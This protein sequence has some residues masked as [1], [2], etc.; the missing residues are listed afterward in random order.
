MDRQAAMKLLEDTFGDSF[1][2][3][4]FSKFVKELFNKFD[5]SPKSWNVWKEYADYIDAYQLLGSHKQG[6]QVIDVLAVKLKKSTSIERARTMQRNFV[7]KYLGNAGKDAALVAFY[8]EGESDWRFSFVKME[9]RL[10]EGDRGKIKVEKELTPAKRYSFLVGK[11]EPNHTCKRQFLSL[12]MEEEKVP[13]IDDIESA[14]SVEKVTKEFFNEYKD[15]YLEL[16]ES[17]VKVLEKDSRARK[18]F[19]EKGITSVDFSKKLLGQIVFIYFL[20]KKGW[21][22]VSRKEKDGFLSWGSGPKNFLRKL[23][24]KEIVPYDNFFNDILEP[25]FYEALA[26]QRDDDYYSRFNCKIPFLNGG[27]FEPIG[28]Y[29]W[30]TTDI[31]LDNSIFKR[32]LDTFDRYNFTIKEDE[33]LEKEVAIDPEMLGKVFENL[34]EIKDRKSKGSYYT[35]REIVHYMCQ[36][37][38]IN[39]LETNVSIP[40]EDIEKFVQFGEFT[41]AEDERILIRVKEINEEM[42]RSPGKVN[43]F[44]KE[45]RKCID[46]LSLPNTIFA[47]K[48]KIDALLKEVKIV[49]PA[50]GSGAFP[51][52]MMT[53]IVKARSVLTPFFP[54]TERK[55]RTDYNLKR[56]TIENC[57]YGVDI[58][59]SA[60]DITKLRFWLSLIVDELDM[61]NIKPLPN[62]DHKIM[63]GNSLLDEFEG[64]KL[65]DDALLGEV[66]TNGHEKERI[67]KEMKALYLELG[68]IHKGKKKAP[69]S[70]VD[71][72]KKELKKLERRKKALLTEPKDDSGQATLQEAFANKV[73]QSKVKLNELKKL[74]KQFFNEQDRKLKKQYKDQI[75][76]IEWEL[77]EETLKEQGN[78]DAMKKLAQYKKSRSKPFFLWKLYFAEVFQRENPG[79]DIVIAN[80]PYVENKKIDKYEKERYKANYESAY[81]LFDL[82]VL[83]I[84]KTMRILKRE[85]YMVFI[86]TNK[87]LASDYGIKIRRLILDKTSIEKLIDVSHIRVFK[88]AAAFP[89]IIS[90]VNETPKDNSVKIYPDIDNTERFEKGLDELEETIY[91]KDYLLTTDIIFNISS[92]IEIAIKMA[93]DD[94]VVKLSDLEPTFIYRPLGFTDWGTMIKHLEQK[95]SSNSLKFI[96]TPNVEKYHTNWEKPVIVN[97]TKVKKAFMPFQ[98]EY[99]EGWKRL[100]KENLMIKEIALNLT[101]SY[102][103]GNYCHLTGVYGLIT[104]KINQKYLLGL[105]NSR[106]LNFYYKSYY[107]LI[108]L[109]GGY[110]K[111]N[112]SY[113]K[114]LP[115]KII[116]DKGQQPIIKLV[117]QILSITK[118]EDYPNNPDKQTKV[119]KLEKEI[120]Q[121]VY[122]LYGLTEEEIRIVEGR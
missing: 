78:E 19:D 51:V 69:A 107:G 37:S 76:R 86:T 96:S 114:N 60:V 101:V 79:F 77:I 38:L 85:G 54:E 13:E 23:F 44:E 61:K 116:P 111:I 68:E 113:L 119:R 97:K 34:L 98:K 32:I 112:S 36:Q 89:V 75:E 5:F 63:V 105:L 15:L 93:E 40:R 8:Y 95:Q 31:V 58:E 70:R 62:L 106:L 81:K 24:D 6:K 108:H 56:E 53:E 102:S 43:E 82:S 16:E 4:R 26:T 121:L 39:Y 29:D 118:D 110:L 84:E 67:D 72:I 73:K 41:N 71:E 11:D 3:E 48:E 64:V 59:P 2:E 42:I 33:P 103:E 46:D 27:L 9:Y 21:L 90:I 49:D 88:E 94:G 109:S 74:Q 80:P 45:I 18:Q 35:P 12:V 91:Q 20:Q 122:K 120:D 83:F 87:F 52:G 1:N 47:N 17:L 92:N 65:F 22:G 14:F 28:D 7:A 99:A 66:K 30:V 117:D 57:L 115:I 100:K 55:K 10:K 50:V 104:D 25:L